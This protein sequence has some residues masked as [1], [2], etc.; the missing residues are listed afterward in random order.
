MKRYDKWI[1]PFKARMN[2]IRSLNVH[3][4]AA[5]GFAHVYLTQ[6]SVFSLDNESVRGFVMSIKYR[7]IRLVCRHGVQIFTNTEHYVYAHI[8]M[9]GENW[10]YE[11]SLTIITGQE[12]PTTCRHV[13]Q[14]Q[15][16]VKSYKSP[17]KIACTDAGN[18]WPYFALMLCHSNLPAQGVFENHGNVFAESDEWLISGFQSHGAIS[19]A[20]F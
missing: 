20:C 9:C 6:R 4:S 7:T 11:T 19:S 2:K 3:E 5:P 15:S 14:T 16:Q 17:R 18:R 1:T 10:S 12:F 13:T 8:R